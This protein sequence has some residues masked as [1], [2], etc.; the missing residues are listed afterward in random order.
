MG[1]CYLGKGRSGDLPPRPRC[2]PYWHAELLPQLTE[3]RLTSLIDPYTQR[4]Y[5][6]SK[7]RILTDTVAAWRDHLPDYFALP[8]PSPSNNIWLR[9]N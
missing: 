6:N 2:A 1:F 4:Y 8:Q 9:K 7:S 3:V 5:L